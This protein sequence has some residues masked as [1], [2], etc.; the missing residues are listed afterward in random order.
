MDNLTIFK[1]PWILGMVLV[2]PLI[3]IGLAKSWKKF[4][5]KRAEKE[6][7]AKEQPSS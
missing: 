3:I 7:G 6:A 1:D 5:D 4:K 2:T